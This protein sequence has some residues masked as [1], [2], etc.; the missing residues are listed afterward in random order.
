MECGVDGCGGFCGVWEAGRSCEG[1][2]CLNLCVPQC[3]TVNGQP[4]QCG[5]NG[6]GG[7]CGVCPSGAFCNGVACQGG[8][9]TCKGIL[10]CALACSGDMLS[11]AKECA[12]AA[13]GPVADVAL[14]LGA[15]LIQACGPDVSAQCFA[16]AVGGACSADQ[17]A[18]PTSRPRGAF[19]ATRRRQVRW[20]LW[21]CWT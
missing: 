16:K 7:V 10:D 8:G 13:P 14:A 11:C 9:D 19:S 12:A 15:C 20:R 18:A 21:T 6:C 17:A 2:Q 5:D 1:G 3:I 4:K